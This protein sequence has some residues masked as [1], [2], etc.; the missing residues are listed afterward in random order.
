[1]RKES[2]PDSLAARVYRRPSK[3]IINLNCGAAVRR[4]LYTVIL[5]PGAWALQLRPSST[6]APPLPHPRGQDGVTS[7]PPHQRGEGEG[8][9]GSTNGGFMS[10]LLPAYRWTNRSSFLQAS[11]L[12]ISQVILLSSGVIINLTMHWLSNSAGLFMFTVTRLLV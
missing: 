11:M 7:T 6:P 12:F 1:M 2:Y 9:G 3:P 8:G 4:E 5:S 10:F